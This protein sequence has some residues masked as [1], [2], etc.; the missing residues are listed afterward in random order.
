MQEE[1]GCTMGQIEQLI[2]Y[3]FWSS[4]SSGIVIGMSGGIDSSVAATFCCRAIGGNRVL[5]LILPSIVTREEDIT[6]AEELCRT[7][8]MEYRTFGV[9]PL[10]AGFATIPGY[11]ES[12][13][14]RGNLMARIRM[15]VLYYFANRDNRIV[16]GT[17]NRTEYMIGYCTKFG[18]NA[19]DIQ[20][21]IHLYKTDVYRIA[22]ELRIPDSIRNKI[23]SAGL[24][25]G[26]SDEQEIGLSYPII[27]EALRTLEINGWKS[28]NS[29]E[30]KVLQ[31]VRKSE[32]KRISAYHLTTIC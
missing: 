15:T 11:E 24:W 16:C 19:A 7:L 3:A 25:E 22:E 30:E 17:S 26:Q 29:E 4:G 9:D 8:G 21:I 1:M 10:L 18:D 13:Y 31:M 5:G 14:L 20:P 12:P 2:R 32:H 6:D 28:R 27:D 23:P